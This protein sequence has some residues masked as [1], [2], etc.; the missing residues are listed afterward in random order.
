M[1][2]L[3]VGTESGD[4][5]TAAFQL[6]SQLAMDLAEVHGY[7][8]VTTSRLDEDEEEKEPGPEPEEFVTN[9]DTLYKARQVLQDLGYST[10]SVEDIINQLRQAGI[11]LCEKV[12]F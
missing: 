3:G 9:D 6:M 8:N 4:E 2:T 1:I 11:L 7:V 5:H 10:R 12:T